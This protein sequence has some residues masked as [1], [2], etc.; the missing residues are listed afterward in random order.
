MTL[1]SLTG[2]VIRHAK[3]I[4]IREKGDAKTVF[5]WNVHVFF[6]IDS[7]QQ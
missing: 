1:D 4:L 2:D 3:T 6:F 7:S 5:M